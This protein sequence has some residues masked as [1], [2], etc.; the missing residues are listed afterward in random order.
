MYG[1]L[2]CDFYGAD[3]Y[4]CCDFN[5]G[6][7]YMYLCLPVVTCIIYFIQGGSWISGYSGGSR[8]GRYA[9]RRHF[10][11]HMGF[12][13]VRFSTEKPAPVRLCKV[14]VFIPGAGVQ[15]KVF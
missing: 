5:P 10:F 4:V 11:Q 9:F 13:L 3:T 7:I 14:E 1:F 6:I 2:V 15:G 8:F 12:R